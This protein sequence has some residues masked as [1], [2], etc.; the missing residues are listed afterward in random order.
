MELMT[1]GPMNGPYKP[2][3][4]IMLGSDFLCPQNECSGYR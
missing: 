3:N 2:T 1:S 4:F